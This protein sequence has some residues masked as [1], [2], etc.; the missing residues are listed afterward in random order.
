MHQRIQLLATR[1]GLSQVARDENLGPSARIFVLQIVGEE[2][3]RFVVH[4][5][6]AKRLAQRMN[7]AADILLSAGS[8]IGKLKDSFRD[9]KERTLFLCLLNLGVFMNLPAN[10]KKPFVRTLP[11]EAEEAL[12]GQYPEAEHKAIHDFLSQVHTELKVEMPAIQCRDR[13]TLESGIQD[14]Y[15]CFRF[16]RFYQEDNHDEALELSN[17]FS[18]ELNHILKHLLEPIIQ[19]KRE[20]KR[21]FAETVVLQILEAEDTARDL[22]AREALLPRIYNAKK[23]LGEYPD[24]VEQIIDIENRLLPPKM[25]AAR[26]IL[27]DSRFTQDLKDSRN[28]ILRSLL[29]AVSQGQKYA[30]EEKVRRHV[31]AKVKRE[32]HLCDLHS[33]VLTH[34]FPKMD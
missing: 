21:R 8:Q 17:R 18:P 20:E 5:N 32:P 31:E 16:I 12:C 4:A 1:K 23:S 13:E 30:K 29:E 14:L 15:D 34:L 27:E 6:D 11:Q 19:A 10:S 25:I 2:K 9:E 28:Q 7:N 33:R 24:L 3:N 26:E 22:F